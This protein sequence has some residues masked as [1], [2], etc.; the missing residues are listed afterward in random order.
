MSFPFFLPKPPLSARCFRFQWSYWEE[1]SYKAI[2][3]C[4]L[5]FPTL[6]VRLFKTNQKKL[7]ADVVVNSRMRRYCE[8]SGFYKEKEVTLPHKQ[9]NLMKI[10]REAWTAPAL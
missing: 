6:P 9:S 1:N 4:G 3:E 5:L 8:E 7:S 10:R 2:A